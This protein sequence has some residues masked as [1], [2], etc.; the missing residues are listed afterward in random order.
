MNWS[1]VVTLTI[2]E[3]SKLSDGDVSSVRENDGR[4]PVDHLAPTTHRH[5]RE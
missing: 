4:T 1:I 2:S 5:Y 3:C